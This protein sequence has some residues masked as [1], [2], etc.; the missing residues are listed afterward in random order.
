MK[1]LVLALG[2]LLVP[3]IASADIPPPPGYVE[4]CTIKNQCVGDEVGDLCSAWHGD[5]DACKKRHANT[6]F[7]YKCRT[8]GA[9]TWSEVWC[10]PKGSSPFGPKVAPPAP[11]TPPA[12]PAPPPAK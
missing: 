3:V 6:G 11:T 10:G 5:R 12:P 1:S 8:S 2:A 9:S 4:T 7:V